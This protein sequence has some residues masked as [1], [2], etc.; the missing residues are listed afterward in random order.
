MFLEQRCFYIA[1][2]RNFMHNQDITSPLNWPADY[3]DHILGSWPF[4]R[5]CPGNVVRAD[6]QAAHPGHGSK[7]IYL[8]PVSFF[9]SRNCREC[10]QN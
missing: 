7:Q 3:E 2:P 4:P 5:V 1:L 9:L 10:L 8:C 6:C